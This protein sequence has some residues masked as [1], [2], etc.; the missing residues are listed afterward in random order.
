MGL[1]DGSGAAPVGGRGLTGRIVGEGSHCRG[2]PYPRSPRALH[3]H[4]YAVTVTDTHNPRAPPPHPTLCPPL[5]SPTLKRPPQVPARP[6]PLV[7]EQSNKLQGPSPIPLARSAPSLLPP[8]IV[9]RR[10]PGSWLPRPFS[11]HPW[12]G[13]GGR[14]DFHSSW[15]LSRKGLGTPLPPWAA[16]VLPLAALP[17]SLGSEI[18]MEGVGVP[19]LAPS[20]RASS[21]TY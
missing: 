4:R 8:K 21:P 2:A 20:P 10:D 3:S 13:V 7:G 17:P 16:G 1:K 15:S 18:S 6:R 14:P 19:V 5:A 12:V 9:V 11:F